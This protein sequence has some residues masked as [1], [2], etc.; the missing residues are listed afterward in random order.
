MFATDEAPHDPEHN[1]HGCDPTREDVPLVQ[2]A[3]FLRGE[4]GKG[5]RDH[6]QPVEQA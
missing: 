2:D 1:Q 5:D 3:V 4:E 6:Q